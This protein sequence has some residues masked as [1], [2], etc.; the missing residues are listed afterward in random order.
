MMSILMVLF[1]I[2]ILYI[3]NVSIDI[4]FR[5]KPLHDSLTYYYNWMAAVLISV[6]L[7][8]FNM[9]PMATIFV[10]IIVFGVMGVIEYME[11]RN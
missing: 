5:H 4:I 3:I 7:G 1:M 8:I 9:G 2:A 11:E 6:L 10:V